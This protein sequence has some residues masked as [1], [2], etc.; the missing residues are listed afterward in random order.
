MAAGE[1]SAVDRAKEV[2]AALGR[3]IITMGAGG[4][5][6]SMKIAI[7]AIVHSLNQAV[8]EALVL[9]ERAG[10]ERTRAYEVFANSAVAAPFVL[11]RREAYE[12]PGEVPVTFR[13]D[14]AAKDLRLA[15]ALANEVGADL[16]QARTNL[17]VLDDAV[18]AGFGQDD[19]AGVAQHL[20]VAVSGAG[21]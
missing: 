16:P 4:S 10:I 17:A 14:L 7:N 18:A 1:P 2:L 12:R 21:E 11:Y 9:A 5:G 8:A 15:L 6:S 19:E 13:L 3:R 20:R